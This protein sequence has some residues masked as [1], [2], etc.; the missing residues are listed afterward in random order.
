M[1]RKNIFYLF[2]VYFL[3]IFSLFC[4]ASE[5]LPSNILQ[6]DPF[7]NHHVLVAEKSTHKLFLFEFNPGG[8]P[9]LIKKFQMATG[10]KRGDKES[11]GDFKTPEGVYRFTQFIPKK[12]LLKMYGKEGEIYGVGAF[13]M[14]FPNPIDLISNKTGSGIWLHSTN[15]ETRIEKGRDSRG[16]V[17]VAN[18]DLKEISTYIELEKTSII[19]VDKIQYLR[20]DTWIKERQDLN[21]F[22]DSWLR[23]WQEENISVYLSHYSKEHF[24]TPTK[25]NFSSYKK[26]KS[27]VFAGKGRPDIELKNISVF[28]SKNSARIVFSQHYKSNNINDTGRKTLYLKRNKNYEWEIVSELW[29]K[30][31]DNEQ[32][33]INPVAF[34]PTMRF[35][36]TMEN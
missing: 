19:V 11:H 20:Q 35:F 7:F 9:E 6:M 29:H 1:K 4:Q 23:S 28:K 2:V 33:V 5:F 34:R 26:Y 17:V 16:C 3:I 27:A 31:N 14:D 24:T 18:N 22:I 8:T 10:K 13:V 12:N 21:N 36:E 25:K 15:D 30:L 32:T